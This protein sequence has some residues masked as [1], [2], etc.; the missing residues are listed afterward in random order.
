MRPK[1]PEPPL[2]H[3]SN[4]NN[5]APHSQG[6][7]RQAGGTRLCLPLPTPALGL[8]LPQPL[9]QPKGSIPS[10]LCTLLFPASELFPLPDMSTPPPSWLPAPFIL[11][12]GHCLWSLP[13]LSLRQNDSPRVPLAHSLPAGE[14][15]GQD[16]WDL[17]PED[18]PLFRSY[19]PARDPSAPE[20]HLASSE[21]WGQ[22][23]SSCPVLWHVL[24]A[25]EVTLGCRCSC[26]FVHFLEKES[27]LGPA[28]RA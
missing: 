18:C 26:A 21:K 8:S 13:S 17:G 5:E 6:R 4:G 23:P 12:G 10:S 9:P 15:S 20:S 2:T 25:T 16:D 22:E 24:G 19:D 1:L 11:Q 14:V 7:I 27:N 3:L 28:F